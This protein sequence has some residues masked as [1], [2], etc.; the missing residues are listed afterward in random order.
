[1]K[2]S[3]STIPVRPDFDNLSQQHPQDL[4]PFSL[5]SFRQH[6]QFLRLKT[7]KK[8]YTIKFAHTKKNFIIHSI[9]V[10]LTSVGVLFHKSHNKNQPEPTKNLQSVTKYLRLTLVLT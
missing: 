3:S 10:F 6:W 5:S 2:S 9:A 4:F 7:F 8:T 1:M